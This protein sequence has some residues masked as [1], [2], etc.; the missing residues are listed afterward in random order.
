MEKALLDGVVGKNI[1]ETMAFLKE[2]YPDKFGF[3]LLKVHLKS[4]SSSFKDHFFNDVSLGEAVKHL[5]VLTNGQVLLP[6]QVVR[7]VQC[8]LVMPASNAF[9][10]RAFSAMRRIK[11][12]LRNS[13]DQ[14]RLN[15]TI[16]INVYSEKVDSIDVKLLLNGFV[17]S[18]DR[19][20][21]VF[22]QM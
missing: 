14:N 18:N 17:D 9:S 6:D 19:T 11:T 20:K 1:D 16:C 15:H 3:V 12:C 22:A 21:H 13:I 4:F 10:K 8:C 5:R 7:L 2:D